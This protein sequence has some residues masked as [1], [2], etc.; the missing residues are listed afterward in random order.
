MKD[1]FIDLGLPS[2]IIVLSFVLLICGIDG[3]VK[4]ILALAAGWVFKSG[5]TR[6]SAK[7]SQ[8]KKDDAL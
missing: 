5:Y 4:S 7:L 8:K 1:L 2:L 6:T 3:E